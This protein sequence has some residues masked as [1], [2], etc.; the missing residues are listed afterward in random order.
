MAGIFPGLLLAF[1]FMTYIFLHSVITK[2]TPKEKVLSLKETALSVLGIW[3]LL[4][5]V[6]L[7]LGTI[8]LGIATPTEAG[9][10]GA[11]GAIIAAF[12]MKGLTWKTLRQGLEDALNLTV[13]I[14]LIIVGA[15]VMAAV[16]ANLGVPQ[17][18]AEFIVS[19]NLSPLGFIVLISLFYSALGCVMDGLAMVIMTIPILFPI[20]VALGIN[21]VWFGVLVII[22]GEMAAITPPVGINLFIMQGV[23]GEPLH[24]IAKG[25]F[26]FFL[27]L[28]LGIV[29]LVLC[30]EIA[31]WI[32]QTMM[33]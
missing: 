5:L 33:R 12:L 8:Y 15:F 26:P 13:M 31:L 4:L 7:V 25:V 16:L 22:Y 3:P 24:R 27:C 32:P 18:L 19:I 6:S 9:G 17:F 23:T 30:P 29:L 14:G 28:M 20:V 2:K 10:L 11:F 21:P 1:L